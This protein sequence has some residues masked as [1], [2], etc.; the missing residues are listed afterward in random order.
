METQ[1]YS[2]FSFFDDNR[3]INQGLVK[4][5]VE[6][7]KSIGYVKSN[8]IMVNKDNQIIDG[9]HRFCACRE[10]EIPVFYEV[11]DIDH[12]VA[13]VLLNKNQ[14]V[15]GLKD[16]VRFYAKRGIECYNLLYEFEEDHKIGMSNS[17]VIVFDVPVG[18]KIRE[19]H[20]F[21]VNPKREDVY[22]FLMECKKY[23]SFWRTAKFVTAVTTTFRRCSPK[24]IQKLKSKAIIFKQQA[25]IS[26]YMQMFENVIN[27]GR[28]EKIKLVI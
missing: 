25:N 16:Y 4:R 20:N 7:I 1:D 19:G 12:E 24:D 14:T 17:I 28:S 26:D 21:K 10:L 22:E 6:S 11:E 18:R 15:W 8:P 3:P 13:M 27:K 2:L 5:L 9:Q 23:I